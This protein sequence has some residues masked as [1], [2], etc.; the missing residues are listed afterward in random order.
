MTPFFPSKLL[1]RCTIRPL[2]MSAR[3]MDL[4][5]A[6][7]MQRPR[8]RVPMF[9]VEHLNAPGGARVHFVRRSRVTALLE[10]GFAVYMGGGES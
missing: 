10:R 9:R 3:Q 6:W 1:G 5:T 7:I 8:A 4:Y 2:Y